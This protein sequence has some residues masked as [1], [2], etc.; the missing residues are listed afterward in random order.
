MIF[1]HFQFFLFLFFG[2]FVFL[3]ICFFKLA[4]IL[5]VQYT[6]IT[7]RYQEAP[8]LNNLKVLDVSR[9]SGG[10]VP[11]AIWFCVYVS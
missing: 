6:V 8:L 7:R 1:F 2:Y 11:F 10:V 3:L 9:L 5:L 4:S